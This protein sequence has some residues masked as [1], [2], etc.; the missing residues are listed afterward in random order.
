MSAL[1]FDNVRLV[2]PGE[3]ITP[4]RLL[5]EAGTITRVNPPTD[6]CPAGAER[7][8]GGGRLLT[9]GLI[10]MHIHGVATHQFDVSGEAL[11]AGTQTLPSFGVTS[12]A[13]TV[14]P[15]RGPQMLERL[16]A[17]AQAIPSC[18]GATIPGLH[19][20]GPFMALPGAGC[21][22]LPGDVGLL[23]EMIAACDH[24]VAVMSL[25]SETP[26]I[27][28][29]IERLRERNIVPFITHT[30]ATAEETQASIDAGVRHA[31]HFYD[32]FYPPAETDPGVRPTG[33][34]EA[35]LA[36]PSVSVD[37]IADGAHVHPMAI[38]AA[39]AAKGWQGVMLISDANI[40]AGLPE[41][42]YDTPWGYPVY[43]RA[44]HGARIAGDHPL[45]GV[46]AGSALTMNVGIANLLNWLSIPPAQVWAMGSL[47]P[48]RLLG[49][50]SKGHLNVGADA[51][52]V[53]WDDDLQ[54]AKTWV[55]GALVFAR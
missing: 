24:R 48:A 49:L 52:L 11:A 28:P 46:L 4:G 15:K 22:T 10:D 13:A 21:D 40:G 12:V 38:R 42:L 9:P 29:V 54:A 55:G 53:L 51:D 50:S 41:G 26:N 18:Q 19:I 47:N 43:V 44:G 2:F 25:S 35:V 33:V 16:A 14:V 34:V 23:D 45:K 7:V 39:L 27:L 1:W 20:E 17:I 32:V 5:V 6:A 30:R 37:F 31:T 8:D 3:D 36:N